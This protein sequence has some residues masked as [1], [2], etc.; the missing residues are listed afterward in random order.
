MYIEYL[1]IKKVATTYD[2]N[3]ILFHKNFHY[4]AAVI[5]FLSGENLCL[6]NRKN[7]KVILSGA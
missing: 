5:L 3:V 1:Y 6:L 4:Y 2:L 7:M